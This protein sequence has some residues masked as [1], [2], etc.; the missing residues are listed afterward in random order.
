M[1][2]QR[3]SRR[4]PPPRIGEDPSLYLFYYAGLG[5]LL[6]SIVLL[7]VL[8]GFSTHPAISV[9]RNLVAGI[10]QLISSS[11]WDEF[12]YNWY[13]LTRVPS[14]S[15]RAF[16]SV[17]SIIREASARYEVSPD[18]VFAMIEVESQFNSG[19][20]SRRGALGLMQ[21]MPD[22]AADMNVSNPF[23]PEENIHGGTKYIRTLLN[24][25]SGNMNLALAAY[26]AGPRT[27]DRFR[28][29]PPYPETRSYVRKVL[30]SYQARIAARGDDLNPKAFRG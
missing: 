27:V 7:G 17:K 21:L 18:L 2:T 26:N 6:L 30:R 3:R 24:K 19:A 25:Y 4:S 8:I 1:V 22:T 29:V 23:D 5:S 15:A 16:R 10:P 11:S 20:V 12:R 13:T 9:A 14:P 28:A